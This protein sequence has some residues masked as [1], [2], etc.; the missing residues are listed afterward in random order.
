MIKMMIQYYL[1]FK[2]INELVNRSDK[3]DKICNSVSLLLMVI[4]VLIIILEISKII[5]SK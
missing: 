4:N 2:L 1:L 5:K 3:G